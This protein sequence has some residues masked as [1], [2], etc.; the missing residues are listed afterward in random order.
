MSRPVR[1]T[2]TG[3]IGAPTGT[4]MALVALTA[5]AAAATLVLREGGSGGTIIATVAAP[6]NTTVAVPYGG[7]EISGQL[8]GTLTGASAEATIELPTGA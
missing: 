7:V 1:I 8:H 6:A 2:A 4:R 3:N 5:A